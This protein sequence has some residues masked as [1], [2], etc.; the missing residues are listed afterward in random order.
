MKS[1]DV[2]YEVRSGV[3]NFKEVVATGTVAVTAADEL[4]A[5]DAG[6]AH[7]HDTVPQADPR[8][9]P[10]VTITDVARSDDE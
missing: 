9:D 6:L 8:L 4:G 5:F 7:V 3:D 2:T 10:K 1:W